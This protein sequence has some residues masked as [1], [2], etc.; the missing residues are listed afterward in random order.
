MGNK[1]PLA[2]RLKSRHNWRS[3]L[4]SFDSNILQ[5][6]FW[7]LN[8]IAIKII[9]HFFQNAFISIPKF[10]HSTN[11]VEIQFYYFIPA[12]VNEFS[13]NNNKAIN[14]FGTRS[15]KS[16]KN[17]KLTYSISKCMLNN[18][19]FR[20]SKLYGLKVILKPIRLHYPYLNSHI[21]AQYIAKNLKNNSFGRIQKI[22]FKKAKLIAINNNFISKSID[23]SMASKL[24]DSP[25][26]L[27]KF[28]KFSSQLLV[29]QYLTGIKIQIAGRLSKRK[30]AS[31]SSIVKK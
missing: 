23:K 5:K 11:K 18:I 24:L 19:T 29:P 3:T 26:L 9:N 30:S 2:Q 15:S 14:R 13:N 22:L 21:L 12:I 6:N 10:N 20:L 4:Y 1:H 28:I 16:I 8:N 17:N 31:R 25:L 7:E 27:S